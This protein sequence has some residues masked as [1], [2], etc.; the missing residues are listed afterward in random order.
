MIVNHISNIDRYREVIP[1]F[2]LIRA[3]IAQGLDSYSAGRTDILNPDVY[4][5]R[6]DSEQPA[7]SSHLLEVHR[8]YLDIHV[9]LA[10]TDRI[11]FKDLAACSELEKEFDLDGDYGLYKDKHDG[12]LT[13]PANYFCLIDPSMA[14]MAM[15]G[16]G[17][18]S[19][20][21]IKVKCK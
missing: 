17:S 8:G 19:K 5:I 4:I 11:I 21:V 1:H 7:S 3:A 12:Y 2:E 9:T 20:V 6:I 16:A 15:T 18:I 10:G 14:H 13:V